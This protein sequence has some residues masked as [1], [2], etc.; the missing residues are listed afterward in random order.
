[1]VKIY[2]EPNQHRESVKK[3]TSFKSGILIKICL[4]VAIDE[5]HIIFKGVYIYIYPNKDQ[6]HVFTFFSIYYIIA[7]PKVS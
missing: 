4:T 5:T 7:T 2:I 6:I 1:V 3:K